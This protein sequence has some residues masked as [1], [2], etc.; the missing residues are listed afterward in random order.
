MSRNALYTEKPIG[1]AQN[2]NQ[3]ENKWYVFYTAPRAEK[4]VQRELELRGYDAYLPL[5][6]THRVWK[7]RQKKIIEEV[8]F[9]SYIFVSTNESKLHGIKQI[10][11]VMTYIHCGGKPSV[12]NDKAITG[13]K[14]MLALNSEVSVEPLLAKGQRVRITSGPMDG[15]EG[16][17]AV[18]NSKTKFGIEIDEI[19]QIVFVDIT[20]S[21]VTVI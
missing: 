7:N 2:V 18:K 19:N 6:K 1:V 5:V 20:K 14:N 3:K 17:L 15:Y 16:V 21:D 12:I 9:P 8:L 11:R 13:I 10:A 4:V